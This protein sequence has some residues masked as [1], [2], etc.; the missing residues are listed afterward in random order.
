M[1]YLFLILFFIIIINLSAQEWTNISPFPANN[2]GILGNFISSEK[3]WIFQGSSDS[4]KDIY[5]TE[6]GGQNWE[7]IYSLEDSLEFFTTLNMIDSLHGWATKMWIN[8]QYPYNHFKYYLKTTD[9]GYSW[10]IMNEYIPD[11]NYAYP[12]YF[13]DQDI[14]FFCGSSDSLNFSAS[15]YKTID[16]GFN[17]YLTE[18]PA[19]YDPY[20]Y[21]VNYSVVKFFFL[22]DNNGWAACAALIDFG[23]SLFT[24]DGGENWEVG[25]EPGPPNVYDIHFVNPDYGGAVGRNA[26]YS[27]VYI[28]ENNFQ[29]ILYSYGSWASEMGQFAKAICFQNDSTIWVT[30]SPGIIYCSIDAGAT[31]EV[32]QIIDADL[33]TIQFFGN[34]GYLFG[35]QNALLQYIEPLAIDNGMGILQGLNVIAYPNPFNPEIN[36]AFN[37]PEDGKVELSI[38]NIKGQKIKTLTHDEFTKGD[39]SFVWNGNDESGKSVSSGVYIYKLKVNGKIE[40]TKKMLL[41]K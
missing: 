9:G 18:T 3:G 26:F 32:F 24:I 33:N 31:F 35:S 7:I 17:W 34:T 28:T 19:V 41:L 12:F 4:A 2:I 8:N 15:I 37:L 14:G 40:G 1:K 13:V 23:L 25:I 39:H 20:P 38:Y 16:G 6:D 36:I 5:F 22:D 29:T 27:F 21:L 30:G 11:L 10:D